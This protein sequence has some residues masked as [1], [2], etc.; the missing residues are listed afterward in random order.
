MGWVGAALPLSVE[1]LKTR[2]AGLRGD[3]RRRMAGLLIFA[4]GG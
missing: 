4:L 2:L 1:T 3:V